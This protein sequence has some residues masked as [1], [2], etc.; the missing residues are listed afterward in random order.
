MTAS[1]TTS[2]LIHTAG[3]AKTFAVGGFWPG[4]AKKHVPALA[5]VDLSVGAGTIHGIIGPN[6]SGKTTLLRILATMVLPDNG[7]A[8]VG[9]ADVVDRPLAVRRLI[10][11]STG[12]ERSLYWRL[13]PRQ[14]LEFAAALFGVADPTAAIPAALELV[15]LADDAD[16]PVSGFSQGMARRLGLAR[17]L[18][19][20]PPVLLLDEPT[21]SLDPSATAHF[22]DVLRSIQRDRGVTTVLTTHDLAEAA[23]CCDEVT[24]LSAGRVAG[25]VTPATEA[26][27]RQAV[28]ELLA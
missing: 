6:G 28:S 22:H 18:L 23:E 7:T 16:R 14:N 20:Q 8:R 27:P 1:A 11:F 26:S 10:G 12:E 5:G 25:R 19:H 4:R 9:D 21:R 17:A 13:S 15:G 2:P 24:A 3:L